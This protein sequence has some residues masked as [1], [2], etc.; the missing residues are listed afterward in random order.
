MD[1][2]LLLGVT[3][4]ITIQALVLGLCAVEMPS[5]LHVISDMLPQP[6]PLSKMFIAEFTFVL[7]FIKM[8]WQM[9]GNIAF[10]VFSNKPEKGHT[11]GKEILTI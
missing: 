6:V 3:H 10:R 5:A 7:S 4:K 8:D 1:F 9:I 2:D 11:G